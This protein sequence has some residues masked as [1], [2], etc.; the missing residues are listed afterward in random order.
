MSA[1]RYL[2]KAVTAIVTISVALLAGV[3]P[4]RHWAQ[5]DEWVPASR[6]AFASAIATFL[7]AAAIGIPGYLGHVQANSTAATELMLQAL[8]IRPAPGVGMQAAERKAQATRGAAYLSFM[9][10]LFTPVG[11]LSTYLGATGAARSVAA[12]VDDPWGDPILTI[13]D[14]LLLKRRTA[15][16]TLRATRAREELEGP[17]VPD[18]LIPGQ[19]AGFPDAD[20]VVVASRQKPGWQKGV[21]VITPDTWYR[22]GTPVE[23]HL[24]AGLRTLYPLT[25]IRDL[26][27]R[28]TSVDY[29]LPPLSGSVSHSERNEP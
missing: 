29:D 26:E 9:T 5:C 11:L 1:L 17:E 4:R 22:L 18:R 6:A 8:G 10:F 20:F 16:A 21:F 23:R 7:V 27:V 3:L 13:V 2:W 25:E 28:R 12:Y 14:S 15:A 19:A 24:H